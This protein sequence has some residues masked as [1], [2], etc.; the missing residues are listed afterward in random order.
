MAD[1][2]DRTAKDLELLDQAAINEIRRRAAAI[3]KGEAGECHHCGDL[4]IR[5]VRN[6]C[7]RCRDLLGRP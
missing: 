6:H 3:P 1:D 2:V 4:F 7:G 5:L